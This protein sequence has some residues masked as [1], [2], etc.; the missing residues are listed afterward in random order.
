MSDRDALT[1]RFSVLTRRTTD[2]AGRP[3]AAIAA[4][5]LVV[6]WGAA[7]PAMHFSDTW[8]LLINTPTTI[9]TFIMVFLLQNAQDRDTATINAKLDELLLSMEEAD[10]DVVGLDAKPQSEVDEKRE[11]R[12]AESG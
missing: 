9:V 2:L 3:I 7:G 12:L 10:D 6:V 4:V 1:D 8:Q 5:G 11:R